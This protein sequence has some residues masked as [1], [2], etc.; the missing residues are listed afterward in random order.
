MNLTQVFKLVGRVYV[1]YV[2]ELTELA[3]LTGMQLGP[4]RER[5]SRQLEDYL[6]QRYPQHRFSISGMLLFSPAPKLT[7]PGKQA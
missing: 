6:S 3:P 5:L 2:Q 4:L 7:L 1:G